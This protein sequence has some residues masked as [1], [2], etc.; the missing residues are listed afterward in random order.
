MRLVTS[1]AP[2]QTAVGPERAEMQWWSV[3]VLEA[4]PDGVV[5][6]EAGVV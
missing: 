6:R 4:T 5:V 2:C 3:V 1:S